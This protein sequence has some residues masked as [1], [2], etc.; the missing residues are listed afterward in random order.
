MKSQNTYLLSSAKEPI[1]ISKQF[2]YFE[3]EKNALTTE[4]AACSNEFK[5]IDVEVPNYDVS[6]STIWGKLKLT[7]KEEEQ[8][9][10]SFDPP[11]F[12]EVSIFQRRGK[13]VW[14]EKKEGSAIPVES[15]TFAVN[16]LFYKLDLHPGDTTLVLFKLKDYYPIQID[17]KVGTLS[18]FVTEFHDIDLFN[19]TCFGVIIMMLLYNLYLFIT[20][21]GKAYFIYVMYVFFSLAFTAYVNGYALHFPSFLSAIFH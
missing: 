7:C 10:L 15:K 9:Y 5:A 8:W 6:K 1:R 3:D 12:N 2:L 21:K 13:G 4:A 18:S 19:C 14:E 20:Q 11:T 16:H 17:I